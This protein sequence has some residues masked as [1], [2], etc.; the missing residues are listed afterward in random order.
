ME[1]ILWTD[2]RGIDSMHLGRQHIK[3]GQFKIKQTKTGK[4][5]TIPVAPQLLEAL[6]ASNPNLTPRRFS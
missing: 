2:Q 6:I 1:L 3:N 5:L 4:I